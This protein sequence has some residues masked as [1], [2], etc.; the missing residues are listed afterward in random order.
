MT[1][2]NGDDKARESAVE[3]F[4]NLAT[5]PSALHYHLRPKADV[6]FGHYWPYG[7]PEALP[8][9]AH[10]SMYF[11]QDAKPFTI[12]HTQEQLFRHGVMC[13]YFPLSI[14]KPVGWD[15]EAEAEEMRVIREYMA[16]LVW[17]G[18]IQ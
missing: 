10:I 16:W 12:G 1:N 11:D 18:V 5:R 15:P 3:K 7:A 8:D 2:G 4:R 6:K 17:F 13:P 14:G 9:D